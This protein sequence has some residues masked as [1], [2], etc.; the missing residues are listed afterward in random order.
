M[1]IHN[2]AERLKNTRVPIPRISGEDLP[3]MEDEWMKK[4]F[5]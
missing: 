5:D 4:E 1:N 2:K 3:I